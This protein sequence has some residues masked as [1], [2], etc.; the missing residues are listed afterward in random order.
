MHYYNTGK[1]FGHKIINIIEKRMN[2]DEINIVHQEDKNNFVYEDKDLSRNK[3][4]LEYNTQNRI[5]DIEHTFVPPAMRGCGVAGALVKA[6][7]VFAVSRNLPV[8]LSCWYAAGFVKKF[9]AFGAKV[10]K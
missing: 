6:G 4:F 8:R 2:G 3:A 10:V 7:L 5:L 9:G 1:C